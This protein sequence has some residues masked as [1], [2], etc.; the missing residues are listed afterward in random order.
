LKDNVLLPISIL[1]LL[2]LLAKISNWI[3]DYDGQTIGILNT[4]MFVFLGVVWLVFGF[5]NDNRKAGAIII[6]CGLY[7]M[8]W[9]FLPENDFFNVV[10]ILCL[11]VPVL[12]GR[13]QKNKAE[14]AEA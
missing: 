11:L 12:I 2:I 5:F 4:V 10:G 6:A 7:L 9:S 8:A 1:A 3:F 13:F 14:K